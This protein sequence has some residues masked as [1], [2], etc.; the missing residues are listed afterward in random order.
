[1]QGRNVFIIGCGS[2]GQGLIP[3]LFKHFYM[4][5]SRV[6]VIT[7]DERG[8]ALAQYYGCSFLIEP[9]GPLNFEYVLD[10]VG[11][12]P[13]DIMINVSVD[14]SSI[15][16]MNYCNEHGLMYT[17]TCVEPWRGGYQQGMTNAGLRTAALMSRKIEDT[18][19]ALIAH[20]ANPGLVT[21]LL[22]EG[23]RELSYE[24]RVIYD[25][26]ATA[27]S[28]FG[29]KAVHIAER[30][31]QDNDEERPSGKF[32]NTW[33]VD[34]LLSELYQQ[35]EIGVGTHEPFNHN[36]FPTSR[37]S[38]KL[39]T[40]SA[41][42]KVKSWVPSGG[43]QDAYLITHH[44]SISL[45]AFLEDSDGNRPTVLYA[46]N[47]SR[48]TRESIEEWR[49]TGLQEPKHKEVMKGV[50]QG[51]D[52]LGVLMIGPSHSYWYGSKLYAEDARKLMPQDS[53]HLIEGFNAT[54]LQVTATLIGGLKWMLK[55]PNEGVVEAEDIDSSLVLKYAH[56]YIG[57]VRGHFTAW[58]FG[59]CSFN[60]FLIQ[61]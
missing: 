24:R 22:K 49:A 54:T 61:K 60:N 2:I 40:R 1:M 35:A 41:D 21:H 28:A 58:S 34:G 32:V 17:D 9:L 4:E 7:A 38:A 46:Y 51:F 36:M 25:H 47:P 52:E 14:V 27:F 59:N 15:D 6:V 3:L 45:A 20:G 13:G 31:T 12:K 18:P 42:T 30:D 44:E 57:D 37:I 23:L 43:A 48:L 53:L 19:T 5:Q 39:P 33:S 26:E 11:H 8:K 50:T 55:W 29:F 56:Q 10:N 16:L